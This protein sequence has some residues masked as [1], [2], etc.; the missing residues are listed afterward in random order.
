MS[1]LLVLF[2][3][4]LFFFVRYRAIPIG[5]MK[6]GLSDKSAFRSLMVL[7][8][9]SAGVGNVLGVGVAL[10]IAGPGVLFWMCLCAVIA[11]STCFIEVYFSRKL[12]EKEDYGP[13]NYMK[14]A[15]PKYNRILSIFFV[16][17]L[18]ILSI[19]IGNMCQVGSIKTTLSLVPS[20][21]V[22]SI[23]AIIIF[24]STFRYQKI[25]ELMGFFMPFICILYLGTC[26]TSIVVSRQ[27]I[28]PA[29]SLV[30]KGA[31][32]PKSLL[33][34]PIFFV[35]QQGFIFS[36]FSNEAGNGSAALAFSEN[37]SNATPFQAGIMSSF[38][39]LL[40]TVVICLFTGFTILT[41][42][43]FSHLNYQNFDPNQVVYVIEAFQYHFGKIG[44]F[45][46]VVSLISFAMATII[47][48]YYYGCILSK[49]LRIPIFLYRIVYLTCI[50]LSAFFSIVILMQYTNYMN[51]F[52]LTLNMLTLIILSIRFW[53]N[54]SF[55]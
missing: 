25:L 26:L 21:T 39:P 5:K 22:C 38:G 32:Q 13:I 55:E 6:Q 41:N 14:A 19:L 17:G 53:K 29:V 54:L 9:S 24:F 7:L 51:L 18:L 30:F 15:Y 37:K 49:F 45:I 48:W 11:S 27:E 1:L 20:M 42:P 12:C 8:G 46:G 33:G 4:Y 47:S 36:L 43:K 2:G 35:F 40:D 3:G 50:V 23:V 34:V 28:G 31:F 16:I 10:Y 52:L 44:L